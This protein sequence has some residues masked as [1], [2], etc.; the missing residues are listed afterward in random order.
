MSMRYEQNSKFFIFIEAIY[1]IQTNKKPKFQQNNLSAR[2]ISQNFRRFLGAFND[3]K[4]SL[5]IPK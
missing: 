2:E 4:N 1:E 3:T 5:E